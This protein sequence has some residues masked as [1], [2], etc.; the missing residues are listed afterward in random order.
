MIVHGRINTQQ[1][2]R[3][4]SDEEKRLRE[5]LGDTLCLYCSMKQDDGVGRLCEGRM[6]Y[7]ALENYMERE[8][9]V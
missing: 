8:Y 5:E 2:N 3:A 6:C 9:D 1:Y 7:D 4:W